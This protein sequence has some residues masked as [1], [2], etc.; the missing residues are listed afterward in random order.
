MKDK[1]LW[2]FALVLSLFTIFYNILEGLFSVYFGAKDE[3]LALFGF[4]IDSFIEVLSGLG[5]FYM[6]IRTLRNKERNFNFE[7]GALKT[8]GT[9]FYILSIGLTLSVFV[10]LVIGN[11]PETTF[12]GIIISIISIIVMYILIKLKLYVGKKL[13]SDAIIADAYCTKTCLY[14][15][16]ILLLSSLLYESLKIS[17]IDSIGA[18]GISYF[19]FR[20]GKESFEKASKGYCECEL[21]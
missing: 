9:S 1:E 17:Y 2:K 3:T 11:K 6:I 20:E 16:F 19:S 13:N 18:L 8:T 21:D 7:K 5:I 15:S 12:W 10:N 4:G 14:L